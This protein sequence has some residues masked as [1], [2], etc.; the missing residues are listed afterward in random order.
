[1][2]LTPRQQ[3]VARLVAKGLSDKRI[4]REVGLSLHTVRNH[5]QNAADRLPGDGPRR[6]RL[7]VFYLTE[8]E[9]AA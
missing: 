5:I 8:Y 4:A 3:E 1:M 7:V 6:Y 2:T 9:D